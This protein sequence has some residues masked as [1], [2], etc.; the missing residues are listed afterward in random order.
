MDSEELAAIMLM[1]Q[2]QGCHNINVVSPSHVVPQI[3][4]A[5]LLAAQAGLRLPL[6]YNSGG[7]DSMQSLKL[8]DGVVDIYMPDMKYAHEEIALRYSKIPNYPQVN[9]DIVREMHRQVGDLILDD[10]GLALR[11]LLIRH[12]LL[13]NGMAGTQQIVIFLA[14][15]I[16]TETYLNLMDQ[17]RPTYC[18]RQ[19][20][21]INRPITRYEHQEAIDMA[22]NAGLKRLD[23]RRSRSW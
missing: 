4:S 16:S 14:Q 8:L 6:V 2:R 5:L 19:Y 20:P 22:L 23:E 9:Q 13:P 18:A 3:L 21:R 17:Y 12:L 7:Y 10:D 11:G 1:L 15:E